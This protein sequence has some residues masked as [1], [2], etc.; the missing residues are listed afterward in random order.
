MGRKK[1][2][3]KK[4][5]VSNPD[6]GQLLSENL[7]ELILDKDKYD[8]TLNKYK[9]LKKD[10]EYNYSYDIKNKNEKE[11]IELRNEIAKK[12]AEQTDTKNKL[13]RDNFNNIAKIKYLTL[14]FN[15]VKTTGQWIGSTIT[16]SFK[17]FIS[18]LN[19]GNGAIIRFL[20]FLLMI[21]LIF[22]SIGYSIYLGVNQT[23]GSR[24]NDNV[25]S[26]KIINNED[27]Y[28]KSPVVSSN[29]IIIFTNWISSLIPDNA[30]YNYNSTVNSI[31]YIIT[32][33]NQYD[34]KAEP[35]NTTD[36][37]RSDNIFNFN[38]N[39]TVTSS[40]ITYYPNN[41]YSLLKPKNII[42]EYNANL[43]PNSDYKKL[44]RFA[45]KYFEITKTQ[46]IQ[47]ITDSSGKY[48]LDVNGN[49][50]L[51][52][53]KDNGYIFKSFD[54][55][56]LYILDKIRKYN[57]KINNADI[58]IK[59]TKYNINSSTNSINN[60]YIINSKIIKYNTN[61]S[62]IENNADIINRLKKYKI[63]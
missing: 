37:G 7:K 59:I 41:T 26:N 30:R 18:T 16:E 53:K 54:N 12:K 19:L 58:L 45:D 1:V 43:Y 50:I 33:K 60:A 13:L 57:I 28:I 38:F 42:F 32:G 21:L 17:I 29:P 56:N 63:K 14:I 5:G 34:A 47:I 25:I 31:N 20:L 23:S 24:I 35:R 22:G 55:N 40:S 36:A 44:D 9:K 51:E 62:I 46:P 48:I 2:I 61:S 27:N 15:F 3:L 49:D 52:R 4:G 8:D 39:N 10:L 6:A 11:D